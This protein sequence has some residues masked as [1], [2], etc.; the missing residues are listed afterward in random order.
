MVSGVSSPG[1]VVEGFEV[2]VRVEA[3]I[4]V[5]WGARWRRRETGQ[6]RGWWRWKL[7]GGAVQVVGNKLEF[8]EDG[9][10]RFVRMCGEVGNLLLYADCVFSLGGDKPYPF[11]VRWLRMQWA[12]GV[13]DSVGDGFPGGLPVFV[14]EL[15]G[16]DGGPKVGVRVVGAVFN[17]EGRGVSPLVTEPL[18]LVADQGGKGKR[19]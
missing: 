14:E 15:D 3:G 18:E 6:L 10:G 4:V 19:R 8:I 16:S 17:N 5:V 1:E 13:G 2:T 9:V 7:G 11:G 12:D